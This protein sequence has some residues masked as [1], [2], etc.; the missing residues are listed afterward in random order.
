MI[1]RRWRILIIFFFTKDQEIGNRG[2]WFK[3]GAINISISEVTSNEQCKPKLTLVE[4]V[5]EFP[6]SAGCLFLFPVIF[7]AFHSRQVHSWTS[8]MFFLYLHL[9]VQ[10]TCSTRKEKGSRSRFGANEPAMCCCLPCGL[11]YA[12]KKS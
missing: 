10:L 9:S 4:E 1:K 5:I 11:G 12:N 7:I 2:V 8:I 3:C 6:I